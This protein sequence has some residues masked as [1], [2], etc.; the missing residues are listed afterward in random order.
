[1]KLYDLHRGEAFYLNPNQKKGKN[2]CIL[3]SSVTEKMYIF[4]HIDGRYSCVTDTDNNV[5]HFVAWME[6]N[7]V[8][9]T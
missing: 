5:Y 8:N 1:M 4:N 2:P 9:N 3:P 6:V 7:P